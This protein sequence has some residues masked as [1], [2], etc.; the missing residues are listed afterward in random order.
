MCGIIGYVRKKGASSEAV[1]ALFRNLLL[2]DERRGRDSTGFLG[3]SVSA[4]KAYLVKAPFPARKFLMKE[5]ILDKIKVLAQTSDVLLGHNRAATRGR[6][7]GR[8]AQPIVATVRESRLALIHNGTFP[9]RFVTRSAR[10]LRDSEGS[11]WLQREVGRLTDSSDTEIFTYRLAMESRDSS[12]PSALEKIFREV[13]LSDTD[14][15]F[16]D[17]SSY[18]I[19]VLEISSGE[20]FLTRNERRPATGFVIPEGPIC[21]TWFVSDP[22]IFEDALIPLIG[23][24]GITAR[25]VRDCL[26]QGRSLPPWRIFRVRAEGFELVQD[27]SGI[28]REKERKIRER[29][30][31]SVFQRRGFFDQTFLVPRARGERVFSDSRQQARSQPRQPQELESVVPP[32]I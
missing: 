7:D 16:L 22:A 32:E 14:G 12:I 20:L 29:E 31:G 30:R 2:M 4:G 9:E 21:G 11:D 24:R 27:L 8:R 19:A 18:A 3:Y 6:V 28:P 17:G 10:A 23:L 26:E 15:F 5:G 13:E 25:Y 1:E